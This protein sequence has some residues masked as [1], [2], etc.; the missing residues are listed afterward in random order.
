VDIATKTWTTTNEMS[1]SGFPDGL[2]DLMQQSDIGA[3][4]RVSY[5]HLV[6]VLAAFLPASARKCFRV[7]LVTLLASLDTSGIVLPK[8][9]SSHRA[10]QRSQRSLASGQLVHM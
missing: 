3:E 6:T 8:T 7:H 4:P 2:R 5:R 1:F 10:H 9:R